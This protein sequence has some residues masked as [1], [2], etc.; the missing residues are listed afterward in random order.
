MNRVK[1]LPQSAIEGTHYNKND[2]NRRLKAYRVANNSTVAEPSVCD[3]FADSSN[4]GISIL[5]VNAL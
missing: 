5:K 3:F 4:G 1:E 2:M